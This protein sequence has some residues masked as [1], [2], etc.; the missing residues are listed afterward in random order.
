MA[1]LFFRDREKEENSELNEEGEENETITLAP[2]SVKHLLRQVRNN[3]A[4][5]QKVV[6][7]RELTYLQK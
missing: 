3:Q 6:D 5:L 2:D 7:Q 1:P 4:R